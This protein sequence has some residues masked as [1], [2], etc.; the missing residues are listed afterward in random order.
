M[1]ALVASVTLLV[2]CN[3]YAS[4]PCNQ[5]R[6][7]VKQ[8]HAQFQNQIVYTHPYQQAIVLKQINPGYGYYSVGDEVRTDAIVERLAR[9]L[10]E[11]MMAGKQSGIK[12]NEQ[13]AAPAGAKILAAKCAN[14][15]KEGTKSVT[16]KGSPVLFDAGNNWI[17]SRDNTI[18][19][20][21][22]VKLGSMPPEEGKEL[23]DEDFITIRAF[24]DGFTRKGE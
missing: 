21:S 5:Q 7:I 12:G 1:K 17:A 13:Y 9:R 8:N 4:P 15:H 14:C 16:E 22:A 10:E 20:V 23:S 11:K 18:K 3:A 6:V 2:C 24:L 19:A